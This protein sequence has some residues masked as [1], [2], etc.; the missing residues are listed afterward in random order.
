MIIFEFTKINSIYI[1]LHNKKQ[2]Y[3]S[4]NKENRKDRLYTLHSNFMDG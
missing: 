1:C 2:K 3:G 4:M